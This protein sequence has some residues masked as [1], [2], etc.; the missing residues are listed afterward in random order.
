MAEL[1]SHQM[2]G[3]IDKEKPKSLKSLQIHVTSTAVWAK[4]RYSALVEERATVGYFLVLQ[5]TKFEL[6]NTHNSLMDLLSKV[7]PA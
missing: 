4:D 2:V 3:L 1:L 6:R 7:Q 5:L